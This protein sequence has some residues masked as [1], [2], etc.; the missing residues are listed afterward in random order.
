MQILDVEAM[1]RSGRIDMSG[2][3]AKPG[4]SFNPD[5]EKLK[6]LNHQYQ[7]ING[8]IPKGGVVPSRDMTNARGVS[9]R[10]CKP[11]E[12]TIFLGGNSYV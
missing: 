1:L 8:R 9:A 10:S 11:K 2:F 6:S 7:K 12:K 4:G 3:G 5:N